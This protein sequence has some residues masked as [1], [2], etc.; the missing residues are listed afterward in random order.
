[1]EQ[2]HEIKY[3]EYV[4]KDKGIEKV[5][6]EN[7]VINSKQVVGAI[8]LLVNE[9]KECAKVLHKSLLIPTLLYES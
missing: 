6:S 4:V 3:L 7:K 1:M 9:T 8:K 2:V 5:E